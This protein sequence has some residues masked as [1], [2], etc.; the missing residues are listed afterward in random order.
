MCAQRLLRREASLRSLVPL[1]WAGV[2]DSSSD[3]HAPIETFA[4]GG[5]V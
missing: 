1:G 4:A 2:R 3:G 5:A